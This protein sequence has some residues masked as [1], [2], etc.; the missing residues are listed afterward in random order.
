MS[1]WSGIIL[2]FIILPDVHF[3][4]DT[5]R[6][7]VRDLPFAR[8][9]PVGEPGSTPPNRR[10]A[11]IREKTPPIDF[12]GPPIMGLAIPHPERLA[13]VIVEPETVV[14]WHRKGFRLFWTWKVRHGQPGRP[15]ISR[16]VRD[17]IRKMCRE[18]PCWGAPRIPGEL[19]KIGIDPGRAASAN[20]WCAAASRRLKLGAHSWRITPHSCPLS[21]SSPYPPSVSRSFT[22][23]WCWPM[24]GV[25]FCT[26]QKLRNSRFLGC[27][28]W[29]D[30]VS[31]A[32]GFPLELLNL[33]LPV[34]K[35]V[36]VGSFVHVFHPVAQHAV[37]QAGQLGRHGLNGHRSP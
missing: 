12:S 5:F 15:V 14:A 9:P 7:S 17:L 27:R 28:N 1:E 26:P 6:H 22:C 10:A 33:E 25:A 34:L 30:L 37:N 16:E 23:F 35:L 3:S 20:T 24:T 31:Q 4:H 18:N 21:T 19:L 29:D 2:S 11:T 32:G 36:E 13:L 8:C